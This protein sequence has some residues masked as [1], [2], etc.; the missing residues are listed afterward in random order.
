MIAA[1]ALGQES[2]INCLGLGSSA[3]LPSYD[4]YTREGLSSIP[5]LQ[6]QGGPSSR[7][8]FTLTDLGHHG[9]LLAG[10]RSSPAKAMDDCWLFKKDSQR[11]ERIPNLPIPLY[12]HSISRLTGSS[13]ALVLGGRSGDT[14]L[15]DLA[16]V[17]HPQK[18]WL[19]CRR[20]GAV[21]PE[22]VFGAILTCCGRKPERHPIF[23]GFLAGGL[24]SDGV[25]VEQVLAWSL[26]FEHDNVSKHRPFNSFTVVLTLLGSN[27]HFLPSR[28]CRSRDERPRVKVRSCVHPGRGF[29]D[30]S[31]RCGM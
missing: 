14:G 29:F 7:M 24:S 2:I 11:W 9:V 10:G 25:I 31:R 18:G 30:P 17:Y 16:I 13:L 21:H 20:G 26:S 19:E 15:S 5:H 4:V 8:C 22:P 28:E 12:R 6:F 3:R 23:H 27:H 1:D